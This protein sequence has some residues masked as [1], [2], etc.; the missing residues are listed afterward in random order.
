MYDF[1]DSDYLWH[2]LLPRD[3]LPLDILP[4]NDL[5]KLSAAE[6]QASAIRALRLQVN[7]ARKHPRIAR[8]NAANPLYAFP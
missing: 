2:Q 3:D 8:M 6:L 4:D 5:R 7:W 1:V